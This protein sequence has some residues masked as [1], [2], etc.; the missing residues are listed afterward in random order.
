MQTDLFKKSAILI[1]QKPLEGLLYGDILSAN[2]F[3]VYIAKSVMDALLKI[4]EKPQDLVLID[5]DFASQ[6]FVEKF[7]GKLR[8]DTQCKNTAIVG[9][10]VYNR[11]DQENIADMLDGILT[12]PCSIDRFTTGVFFSIENVNGRNDSAA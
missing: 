9:I 12:K 1:N 3:D 8:N 6:K 7:I 10:S 2:G 11:E 4:K 5:L